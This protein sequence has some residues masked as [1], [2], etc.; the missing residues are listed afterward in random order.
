MWLQDSTAA[1]DIVIDMGRDDQNAHGW[2]RRNRLAVQRTEILPVNLLEGFNSSLYGLNGG[3][4]K[5]HLL[6]VMMA[7]AFHRLLR[8]PPVA[9]PESVDDLRTPDS[10]S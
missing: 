3:R 10:T 4:D 5:H 2:W 6:L 7:M 8:F 1:N 9:L